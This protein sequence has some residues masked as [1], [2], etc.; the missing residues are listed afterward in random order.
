MLSFDIVTLDIILFWFYFKTS[1]ET[2]IL[3]LKTVDFYS[4]TKLL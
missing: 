2:G 3:K 1:K 4:V